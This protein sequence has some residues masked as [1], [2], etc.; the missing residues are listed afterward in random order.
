MHI[1]GSLSTVVD[2]VVDA[3]V[4]QETLKHSDIITV[5]SHAWSMLAY[6][7]STPPVNSQSWSREK[8]SRASGATAVHT[9]TMEPTQVDCRHTRTTSIH[10]HSEAPKDGG[11]AHWLEDS[12]GSKQTRLQ[13]PHLYI[14]WH[15]GAVF[16]RKEKRQKHPKAVH[17]HHLGD[18]CRMQTRR[19]AAMHD[20][21][22]LSKF[23]V[24]EFSSVRTPGPQQNLVSLVHS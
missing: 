23:R 11:C 9:R 16:A 24:R 21:R 12:I 17:V 14:R 19:A 5:H 8:G 2:T 13:P 10:H 18:L 1:R 3:A 4:E 6:A 20:H 15:H 22:M 7:R